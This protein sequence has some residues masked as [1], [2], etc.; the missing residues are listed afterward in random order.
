MPPTLA[1]LP[2][3]AFALTRPWGDVCPSFNVRLPPKSA[4]S[5]RRSAFDANL[6][7]QLSGLSGHSATLRFPPTPLPSRRIRQLHAAACPGFSRQTRYA[8]RVGAGA[9]T[10][11]RP[12]IGRSPASTPCRQFDKDRPLKAHDRARGPVPTRRIPQQ[13]SGDSE[14]QISGGQHDVRLVHPAITHYVPREQWRDGE[15]LVNLQ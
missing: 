7:R 9:E 6:P 8:W 2:G 10:F 15:H 1:S 13:V 3:G 11:S 5:R 12:R 4:A 14:G